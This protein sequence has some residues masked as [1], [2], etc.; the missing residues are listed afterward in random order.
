MKKDIR[1]YYSDWE[2]WYC[3]VNDCGEVIE[4]TTKELQ[5]HLKEVHKIDVELS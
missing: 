5:R 3:E 4:N 1:E 2:G